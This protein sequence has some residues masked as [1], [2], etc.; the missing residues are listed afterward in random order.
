[1]AR[2]SG[3]ASRASRLARKS[4]FSFVTTRFWTFFTSGPTATQ[5][6]RMRMAATRSTVPR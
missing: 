4:G 2:V 3:P 5:A 1:M 6:S